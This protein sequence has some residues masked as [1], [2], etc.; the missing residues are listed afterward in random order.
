MVCIDDCEG[1]PKKCFN[2][3][4]SRFY[5]ALDDT[6]LP[7]TR[8]SL[9]GS[10]YALM[11][12]MSL[13]SLSFL[14]CR[15]SVDPVLNRGVVLES[16]GR[17]SE[18]ASD[19]RAVLA[20]EPNDPAAWNNLGNVASAEGNWQEALDSYGRAVRLAPGEAGQTGTW[21]H[22]GFLCTMSSWIRVS[23]GIIK[24]YGPC[25][26]SCLTL[27]H[28]ADTFCAG[29]VKDVTGL[30]LQGYLQS[31]I[32]V[33]RCWPTLDEWPLILYDP[34]RIMNLRR[35]TVQLQH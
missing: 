33:G 23:S 3:A 30:L 11:S 2:F 5:S 19:Y 16:L 1:L 21:F 22:V 4:V 29:D 7:S 12:L 14:G 9:E 20:A 6:S 18:A 31:R 34:A 27:R 26:P 17:Y 24:M 25:A 8:V 32:E 28:K 13:M 10:D 15:Y 35:A